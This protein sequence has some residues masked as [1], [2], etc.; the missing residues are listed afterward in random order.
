MPREISFTLL[1]PLMGRSYTVVLF[2]Y[3]QGCPSWLRKGIRSLKEGISLGNA[4]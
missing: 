1:E 3:P 2:Y 4:L